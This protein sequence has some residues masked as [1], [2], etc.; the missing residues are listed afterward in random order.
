MG[1]QVMTPVQIR[2]KGLEPL[3]QHLG[4][5]GMVRF[6]QQAELGGGNYTSDSR[7]GFRTASPTSWGRRHGPLPPAGGTGRRQ[8]HRGAAAVAWQSGSR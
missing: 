6:L 7:K 4:V 1:H 3:R 8:L 5:V 2:E